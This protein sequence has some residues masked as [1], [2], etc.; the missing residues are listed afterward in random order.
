[1]PEVLQVQSRDLTGKRHSQRLRRQ[2]SLPAVLYGHG[3]EPVNLTI[4]E[5]QLKTSLRHGAKVVQLEGAGSGQAL[6]QDIQWD[7]FQKNGLCNDQRKPP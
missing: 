1:M 4:A 2:G 3:K 7:T 5:D 6:F